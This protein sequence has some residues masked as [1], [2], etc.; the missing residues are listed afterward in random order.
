MGMGR[1]IEIKNILRMHRLVLGSKIWTTEIS[2]FHEMG[3]VI[4]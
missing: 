4:H 2:S 3:Y 1:G